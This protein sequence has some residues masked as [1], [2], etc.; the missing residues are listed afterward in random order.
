MIKKINSF[1]N[2]F[3][4]FGLYGVF[5]YS[6]KNLGILDKKKIEE[7]YNKRTIPRLNSLRIDINNKLFKLLENKIFH[8]PYK[9]VKFKS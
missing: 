7:R 2:I 4:N 9:N 6:L 8:G 5:D 3:F 1:K